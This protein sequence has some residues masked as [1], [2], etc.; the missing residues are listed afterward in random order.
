MVSCL[1]GTCNDLW[2]VA[3]CSDCLGWNSLVVEGQIITHWLELVAP[4]LWRRSQHL[5]PPSW[6]WKF[7]TR[8]HNVFHENS[9]FIG[10]HTSTIRARRGGQCP[11]SRISARRLMYSLSLTLWRSYPDTGLSWRPTLQLWARG[12]HL[13]ASSG[14][15]TWT[16][17]SQRLRWHSW[18]P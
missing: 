1:H 18:G 11:K 12:Q 17:P 6:G 9:G 4:L 3:E 10:I 13:T 7:I 5:L 16:L 14:L 8:L 15:S 2:Y